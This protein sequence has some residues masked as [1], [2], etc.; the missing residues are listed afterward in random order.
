MHKCYP[1]PCCGFLTISEPPPGTYEICPIC[2]W[3][4]DI[5]Q[6]NNID[7]QGGANEES[8]NKARQNF[9]KFKA[10]SLKFIK[11]VRSPWPNEI[12]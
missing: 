12:P 4:D 1:C 9:K 2:N 10:S 8:L 11:Q 6:Y 3:E 5:V 7:F